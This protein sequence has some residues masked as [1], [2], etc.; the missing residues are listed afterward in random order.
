MED[1]ALSSIDHVVPR[2]TITLSA[3]KGESYLTLLIFGQLEADICAL[4]DHDKPR[5]R[6]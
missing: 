2:R 4:L 3:L 1:H 5:L 6:G